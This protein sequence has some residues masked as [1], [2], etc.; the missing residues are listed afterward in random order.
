MKHTWSNPNKSWG[1]FRRTKYYLND[2]LLSLPLMTASKEFTTVGVFYK[3]FITDRSVRDLEVEETG[4]GGI[5]IATPGMDKVC[6]MGKSFSCR[7]LRLMIEFQK[8]GI[9]PFSTSWF[10]YDSDS[11][12][13]FAQEAYSFFIVSEN[14]TARERVV[15]FDDSE[16]GFDPAIFGDAA[17][18]SGS[19]SSDKANDR[20]EIRFWYR[21]FYAETYAGQV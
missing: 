13:Q 10:W 18:L 1:G 9:S 4:L 20:A 5:E 14:K 12:T 15:L 16:G 21:K 6:L 2:R 11:A 8:E 17:R 19:W 3:D 7:V